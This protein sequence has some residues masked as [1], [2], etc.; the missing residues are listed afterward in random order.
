MNPPSSVVGQ[1]Q[2]HSSTSLFMAAAALNSSS[3]NT[4]SS[5][6]SQPALKPFIKGERRYP[7]GYP[8]CKWVF[9][10]SNHVLRHHQRVHPG[11]NPRTSS[12]NSNSSAGNNGSNQP[13][14]Q[15]Q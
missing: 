13:Q 11:W 5:S 4:S 9:T 2:Q 12:V 6:S 3:G 10:R 1:Q 15:Q 8:G 7:C 14:P